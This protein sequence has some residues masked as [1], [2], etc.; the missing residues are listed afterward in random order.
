MALEP[1]D[2]EM[3]GYLGLK[4]VDSILRVTCYGLRHLLR[5]EEGTNTAASSG[6]M[7]RLRENLCPSEGQLTNHWTGT[8]YIVSCFAMLYRPER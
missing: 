5:T 3:R 7:M 8:T 4:V 6:S 2:V 1:G